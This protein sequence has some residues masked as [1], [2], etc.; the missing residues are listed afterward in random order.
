MS[1]GR[2]LIL[3]Y[4]RVADLPSD[5]QLLAV[6]PGRFEEHLG[7]I[8][9]RGLETVL[10]SDLAGGTN[11][12]RGD[13]VAITFDD[14]YADNFSHARP[15]L[16][17]YGVKA[18]FFVASDHLEGGREFW[19]DELERLLLPGGAGD[20]TVLSPPRTKAHSAYLKACARM[21]VMPRVRRE[22]VLQ[23]LRRAAGDCGAARPQWRA[24]TTGELRSLDEPGQLEV[25][26]HTLGH[27][28]L[29]AETPQIQL[30]EIQGDKVALETI[31]GRSLTAF[32][33]PYGSVGD[34][35]AVSKAVATGAGYSVACANYPGL[36]LPG[37]DPMELPRNLVRDW[38]GEQFAA[39]L[40]EW[41]TA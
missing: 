3:L 35:D 31:L 6:N 26:G 34:F 12:P 23:G 10:I 25:G 32:S 24:M 37:T 5:P 40:D 11:W 1:Q 18:T 39:R 33:Y 20:W 17:R 4:H 2:V 9:A 13:A 7:V 29:S 8:R 14:G 27:V 38:S 15:I 16:A 21:R 41:L 30:E 19:W 22:R 36:A 28:L